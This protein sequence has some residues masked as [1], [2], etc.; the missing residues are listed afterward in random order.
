[1][2]RSV[3]R[4]LAALMLV[5]AVA[6]G[7]ASAGDVPVY[8]DYGSTDRW[9]NRIYFFSGADIA[10]DSQFGWAGLV[11]APF[12]ALDRDGG[13]FRIAGG[14]GRYRYDTGAVPGGVNE[15]R[16]A[17]AEILFGFR[18]GTGNTI[19]TAYLGANVEDQNLRASD[20]GNPTAG[21]AVGAKVL[22]EF[23]SRLTPEWIVRASAAASTVHRRYS[24][25]AAVAHELP[26]GFAVGLEGSVHGDR[27][28]VEPRAGVFVRTT[29]G[30]S[31]VT[32]SGGALSNS[33]KGGGLYTTLSLYAPY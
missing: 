7:P 13:R 16:V 28:Y 5:I 31:T 30:R 25:R 19:A 26:S 32:L 4:W 11:T 1:M 10:S 21:T 3:G 24:A 12:G 6:A 20:P 29:F 14:A 22:L 15:G 18:R 2:G 27:R 17:T 9:K 8:P 33:D 23:F